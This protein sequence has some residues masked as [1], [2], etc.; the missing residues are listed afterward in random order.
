MSDPLDR[1]N[2]QFAA[3]PVGPEAPEVPGFQD[4]AD[5]WHGKRRHGRLPSRADFDMPSLRPWLGQINFSTMTDRGPWFTL[6][7][8]KNARLLGVDMSKRHLVDFVSPADRDPI[9]AAYRRLAQ[10][11]AVGR[12]EGLAMAE[13]ADGIDVTVLAF[14]TSGDGQAVSGFLHYLDFSRLYQLMRS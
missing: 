8:S 7:G 9:L 3:V 14:P 10:E 11:P 12:F 6:F 1:R 2:V 4:L 13:E 5:L